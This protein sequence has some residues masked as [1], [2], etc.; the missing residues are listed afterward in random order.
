LPL[1]PNL[2]PLM[3]KSR[4]DSQGSV[5]PPNAQG[6]G[7]RG[8]TLPR[9]TLARLQVTSCLLN[10]LDNHNKQRNATA[11][12]SPC[13]SKNSH[14]SL[15]HA[16]RSMFDWSNEALFATVLLVPVAPRRN[17]RRQSG[18]RA[19]G[20]SAERRVHPVPVRFREVWDAVRLPDV[21]SITVSRTAP[22]TDVLRRHPRPVPAR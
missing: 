4:R 15:L 5:C 12:V 21:A 7:N 10:I 6:L 14:A 17:S 1:A 9:S 16:N 18:S 3:P 11:S 22:R 20:Q 8:K 13:S 2:K 19:V